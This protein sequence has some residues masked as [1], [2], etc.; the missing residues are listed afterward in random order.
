M[1]VEA[2]EKEGGGGHVLA[3]HAALPHCYLEI[4]DNC[5]FAYIADR[6]DPS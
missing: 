5:C 1:R 4:I 2:V 3:V 6:S